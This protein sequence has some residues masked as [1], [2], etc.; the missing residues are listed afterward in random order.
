MEFIMSETE[1]LYEQTLKGNQDLTKAGFLNRVIARTIDLII[2]IALYEIIPTIGFFAGMIYLL[3]S[4][5]LFQGRSIGK[6][7][8][9]LKVIIKDGDETNSVCGFKES[10]FRN[11]PFVAGYISFGI[12]KVIPLIGW[13]FSFVIVLGILI[14]ECLVMMG[15]ENG[16][17]LG[18]EIAKTQVVE[19]IQGGLNDS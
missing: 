7:L 15:S 11:F 9:G 12:L 8:I 17:R 2:V 18:D 4:D 6:K 14:F 13:L 1:P 3:I 16:M 5:G 10:I 19:D